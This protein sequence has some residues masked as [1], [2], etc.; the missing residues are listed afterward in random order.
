LGSLSAPRLCGDIQA[1]VHILSINAASK[2]VAGPDL[3]NPACG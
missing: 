1:L 3:S 2:A